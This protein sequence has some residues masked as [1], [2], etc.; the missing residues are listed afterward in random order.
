METIALLPESRAGKSMLAQ[1]ESVLPTLRSDATR[2]VGRT[3]G[4]R[5][6]H[7]PSRTL[8]AF[9]LYCAVRHV[10]VLVDDWDAADEAD[11]GFVERLSRQQ[12][13]R[14]ENGD[15]CAGSLTLVIGGRTLG[16]RRGRWDCW[17]TARVMDCT[18]EPLTLDETRQLCDAAVGRSTVST[19]VLR[20]LHRGCGGMPALLI[21]AL[22]EHGEQPSR[23]SQGAFRDAGHVAGKCPAAGVCYQPSR[24]VTGQL[25]DAL[26]RAAFAVLDLPLAR[27][28]CARVVR[29][30]ATVEPA[31]LALPEWLR[32][33]DATSD[34]PLRVN[35]VRGGLRILYGI[36]SASREL[37]GKACL[38]ALRSRWRSDSVDDQRAL[39]RCVSLSSALLTPWRWHIYRAVML[40]WRAGLYGDTDSLLTACCAHCSDDTLRLRLSVLVAIARCEQGR[41][42]AT[43][44]LHKALAHVRSA[45]WLAIAHWICARCMVRGRQQDGAWSMIRQAH[46]A[47]NA[48]CCVI[49]SSL[50][51][52][53]GCLAVERGENELGWEVYRA[54]RGRA[55]IHGPRSVRTHDGKRSTDPRTTAK[56]H[57]RRACILQRAI[58]VRFRL[59]VRQQ[60]YARAALCARREAALSS[61]SGDQS[62][63]AASLN[64]AGVALIGARQA[65]HSVRILSECVAMREGL[66]DERGLVV[67]LNNLSVAQADAQLPSQAIGTLQRVRMISLRNGLDRHYALSLL[68]LA[69]AYYGTG[70]LNDA[71]DALRRLRVVLTRT[72]DRRAALRGRL[73]SVQI[74][75][76]LGHYSIAQRGLDELAAEP[77]GVEDQEALGVVHV[78]AELLAREGALEQLLLCERDSRLSPGDR[79]FVQMCV[80]R[81]AVSTGR[82]GGGSLVTC[83][84]D[85]RLVRAWL[86][87][88][89]ARY[90]GGVV[91]RC[92]LL[93]CM[94]IAETAGATRCALE[95]VT[96]HLS[97]STAARHMLSGR[98]VVE[99]M[100]RPC[101]REGNPDE[102]A[103]IAALALRASVAGGDFPT[104]K[105]LM[106]VLQERLRECEDRSRRSASSSDLA[107][108]AASFVEE[109]LWGGVSLHASWSLRRS[110]EFR[111]RCTAWLVQQVC[112]AVPSERA[113][114][115]EREASWRGAIESCPGVEAATMDLLRR[116]LTETNAQR[117]ALIV[118]DEGGPIVRAC[119]GA[120]SSGGAADAT[121]VSWTIV[122]NVLREWDARLY[123]DAL[124]QEALASYRSVS[125]HELRSVLCVPVGAMARRWGVLYADHQGVAGLFTKAK[126]ARVKDIATLLGLVQMIGDAEASYKA[127]RQEAEDARL[128][129]FRT[130]KTRIVG[131]ITGGLTHDL[132]NMLAA[133]LGRCELIEQ[134]SGGAAHS[135]GLGSI[136]RAAAA[137]VTV[138][139]KLQDCFRDHSTTAP[140]LV[141]VGATLTEALELMEPRLSRTTR[142][143]ERKI[144]VTCQVDGR[145]WCRASVG[146]LREVFLNLVGNACDAMP[147][148]G[149][150]HCM[151]GI[152]RSPAESRV[153]VR[154]SGCGMSASVLARVFEPFF[155]TK[156]REGTGLGLAV[157]RSTVVRM[158]GEIR[159]ESVEGAGTTFTLYLPRV[160]YAE[161]APK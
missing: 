97:R 78:R 40:L 50:A 70:Q 30:L 150:L 149:T 140:E 152:G 55:A 3:G 157:V 54:L 136:R 66:D 161:G 31:E 112:A 76:E 101:Y 2:G 59:L 77:A 79:R 139:G 110:T 39:L 115:P 12:G 53:Y 119:V 41:A 9:Y 14:V 89:R 81:V 87:L 109:V 35:D 100:S 7:S 34:A 15:A 121:G 20:E 143:I 159:G 37:V 102:H 117:A 145:S 65:R 148:G 99:V 107:R 5:S 52:E 137:G 118:S 47:C 160:D 104:A 146:A 125:Q 86:M 17:S 6:S 153:I 120:S 93:R 63:R 141:E 90:R 135:K 61:L 106:E 72:P 138:L 46:D 57:Y 4:S 71:R 75:T 1:L 124:T 56:R 94:R 128:H 25:S 154:D 11:R 69:Y 123:D 60:C 29:L 33:C 82:E 111:G 116:V 98:D 27:A 88:L 42:D 48:G 18:L 58:R 96:L 64:N 73:L 127:S 36:D 62:R 16:D 49:W 129:L 51:E 74:R 130:Q 26:Q 126:C 23:A 38:E 122:S 22:R 105:V 67:S 114:Q 151:V 147:Q 68:N 21:Q 44:D 155:T 28:E 103:R 91:G 131:E 19:P 132:K 43:Q 133:I 95:W 24:E 92:S 156:G 13:A 10:C 84:G 80:T 32:P 158:G 83:P 134:S 85:S 8:D 108:R 142:G 144:A 113:A 45:S